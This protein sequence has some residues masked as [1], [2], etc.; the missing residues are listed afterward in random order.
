MMTGGAPFA[1]S[2]PFDNCVVP[3]GING[4]VYIFITNTDQPLLSDLATQF[5]ASIVAGPAGAFIDTQTN[6]ISQ[7]LFVNSPSGTNTTSGVTPNAGALVNGT[8]TLSPSAA[9]SLSA[10]LASITPT[11]YR[12]I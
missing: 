9:S 7:L 1:I 12:R 3:A 11:I 10:S 8:T 2:L 4:L 6:T 5:A